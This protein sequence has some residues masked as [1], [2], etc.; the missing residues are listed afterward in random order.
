MLPYHKVSKFGRDNIIELIIKFV[1]RK[2]GAGFSI[3]FIDLEGEWVWVGV[4]GCGW[5]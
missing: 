3:K 2:D 5:V 1:S 4:G